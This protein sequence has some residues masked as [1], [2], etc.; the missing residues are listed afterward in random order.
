MRLRIPVHAESLGVLDDFAVFLFLI[1]TKESRV[2]YFEG[3]TD[4][5]TSHSDGRV[6]A[7]T[8]HPFRQPGSPLAPVAR[9]LS[10]ALN[11]LHVK[12]TDE[13]DAKKRLEHIRTMG[14]DL[15]QKW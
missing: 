15:L 11:L 3:E 6:F 10:G 9:S 14:K 8:G 13:G 12:N 5:D 7:I 1:E 2:T 4:T